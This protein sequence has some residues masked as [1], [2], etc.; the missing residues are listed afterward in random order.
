MERMGRAERM[1]RVKSMRVD[2]VRRVKVVRGVRREVGCM[3]VMLGV[4]LV[5]RIRS[6]VRGC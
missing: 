5:G 6:K 3:V 2:R 4:G 1:R